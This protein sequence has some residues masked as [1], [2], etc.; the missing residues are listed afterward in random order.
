MI[1][2]VDM[3]EAHGHAAL[4]R[5]AIAASKSNPKP[6]AYYGI[7]GVEPRDAEKLLDLLDKMTLVTLARVRHILDA[8]ARG[9]HAPN[10]F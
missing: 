4:Y 5:A 9:H 3:I 8:I 1:H 2:L 6:L 7:L 10:L